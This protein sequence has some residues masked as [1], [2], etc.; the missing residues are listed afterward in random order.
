MYMYRRFLIYWICLIPFVTTF[1][2]N[3][4]WKIIL[5][6]SAMFALPIVHKFILIFPACLPWGYYTA[7]GGSYA[8]QL[9]PGCE[10]V[11]LHGPEDYG[12][13]ATGVCKNVV[14]PGTVGNADLA[15]VPCS[16]TDLTA[17]FAQNTHLP[18][19]STGAMLLS[20]SDCTVYI[21]AWADT[22]SCYV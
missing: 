17:N 20:S 10:T 6:S 15:A 8:D 2:Q 14:S 13:P 12:E 22:V 21:P 18:L 9:S 19:F 7:W 11:L 5:V 16:V 3:H 1:F 4:F